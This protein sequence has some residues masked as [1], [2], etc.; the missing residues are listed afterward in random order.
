MRYKIGKL[1]ITKVYEPLD[2][3]IIYTHN[4]NL[5]SKLWHY[6]LLYVSI[7]FYSMSYL[8]LWMCGISI[9]NT[10]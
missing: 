7:I 5:N 4:N 3:L 2:N 10:L 6:S 8:I 1:Y 9:E